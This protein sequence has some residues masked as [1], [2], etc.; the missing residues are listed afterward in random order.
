M[1]KTNKPYIYTASKTKHAQKW[2]DLR[3]S[4]VNV[5]STWIDEAGEGASPDLHDLCYRCINEAIECDAMIVYSED[6][7][8]LKGA[9]IE[10]GVA[11]AHNKF[12]VLVGNVLPEGSVFTEHEW[13]F[14]LP[15]I[16]AALAFIGH[17]LG[18][19]NSPIA[20]RKNKEV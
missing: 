14:Q 12:V 11:L 6:G 9:F 2:I 7:D 17:R 18:N 3:A 1:R 13:V 5:I 8:Y 15:D 19:F 10:M 16:D 4:G 20:V